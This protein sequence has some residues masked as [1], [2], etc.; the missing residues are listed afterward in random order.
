VPKLSP[1]CRLN[2]GGAKKLLSVFFVESKI[3]FVR[4]DLYEG[5]CFNLSKTEALSKTTTLNPMSLS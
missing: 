4:F 2:Q 3:S 5:T 1:S